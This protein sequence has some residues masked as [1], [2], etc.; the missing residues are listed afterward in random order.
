MKIAI[1]GIRGLPSTYSG[2]ETFATELATRTLAFKGAFDKFKA[3]GKSEEEAFKLAANISKNIST[4]FNRRGMASGLINQLYPFFNAALQGSAR[5]AEVMFE[6]ETY[7]VDKEGVPMLDQRTKLTPFGKI[8]LYSLPALG[9][10]QA[11]LLAMAGYDDED[12]PA[13]IK[14]RAFVVPIWGGKYVA[15]PMPHG[16]NTIINFGREMTDALLNPKEAMHHIGRA[17]LGQVGAFNPFGNAGN[18]VTDML[19]AIFDAPVSLYMNKDAFGRPIAKEAPDS[20]NPTPGFTRAKEGA[21]KTGRVISEAINTITGGNED[22]SGFVSPTPDQ[23][24][25]VLGQFTGGVGREVAKVGGL[26]VAG[27]KDLAG[28]EREQIPLYKLPLAGRLIGSVSEPAALHGKLFEVRSK[29]NDKYAR[30]KGLMERGQTEEA[31]AF[32]DANPEL[33]LRGSVESFARKDSK[34]RKARALARNSGEVGEVNRISAEQDEKL[35]ALLA[36]IDAI[37]RS[38]K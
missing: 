10:V 29:I 24:D 37:R 8:V 38:A 26:A 31:N 22:Q 21:S 30:Y 2:F 20:A 18:W 15:I 9:G 13:Q 16:F 4:N 7:T 19:P 12:V 11:A 17:T 1:A 36:E 25:F 33:A 32:W 3:A 5:L 28:V 6:K 23:I 35:A 27:A 14:D 34:Q